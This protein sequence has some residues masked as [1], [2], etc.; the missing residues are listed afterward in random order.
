M[1]TVEIRLPIRDHFFGINRL[2]NTDRERYTRLAGQLRPFG[3]TP[4]S[5]GGLE[6]KAYG[7]KVTISYTRDDAKALGYI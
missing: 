7:R 5:R 2:Y 4:R 1:E 3:P 6:L